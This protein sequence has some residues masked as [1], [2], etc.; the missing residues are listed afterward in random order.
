MIEVHV[1]GDFVRVER[2]VFT[3]LFENS[4]AHA[5][6]PYQHALV[7]GRIGLDSL[8][9]LARVADVPFSLLFA[10]LAVVERQVALKTEKLLQGLT[11]D[12]FSLS[13]RHKVEL[14]DVELI[15]KDLLRK[16][17]LL[18]SLDPS[19]SKN[20]VVGAMRRRSES[21][22]EDAQRFRALIDLDLEEIRRARTKDAALSLLIAKAEAK[23]IL[24]SQSQN[25]YMP[26]RLV[27]VKFSG[28][29]IK[30]NKVPFVFLAGGD[31]D[32]HGEPAGRRVFT[33]TLM[34]TMVARG[35]FAPVTYDGT[36][37]GPSPG[38]DY[39]LVAEILM[40]TTEIARAH[41]ESLEM[42]QTT[43]D[44]YKVTPSAVVVRA[45][46]LGLLERDAALAHLTDLRNEFAQRKKSQPRPA[47]AINA[48]R[49]YNGV[50][51]SRRML[52][53]VDGGKLTAADF[54]R[55]VCLNKL[56]PQQ[57]AD[58]RAALG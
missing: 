21:L 15:V 45:M 41:T 31:E 32:E 47:K 54:C 44:R 46:R 9:K 56:K 28:M 42:I 8:V 34:L 51:Y 19:V 23:Q 39:D 55:V 48:V 25:L 4:V 6:A 36:S 27:G 10:P 14:R 50:E 49:K 18:K 22:V 17:Q 35:I 11:K 2:A 20:Q 33:L 16:Q 57:I 1:S 30:D 13:S 24:V 3:A 58:F 52:A 38:Y 5:R 40:P 43:A 7:D 53:A 26:Q 37:T 12:S 29:T